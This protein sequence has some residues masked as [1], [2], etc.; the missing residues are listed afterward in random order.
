M[1]FHSSG[2][3]GCGRLPVYVRIWCQHHWPE[4]G[5]TLFTLW[6]TWAGRGSLLEVLYTHARV[7]AS[8]PAT[9]CKLDSVR[10]MALL[11]GVFPWPLLTTVAVL[12]SGSLVDRPCVTWDPLD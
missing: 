9:S 2:P 7:L 12:A 5:L 8:A 3:S 10:V 11:D 1:L 6:S 4:C